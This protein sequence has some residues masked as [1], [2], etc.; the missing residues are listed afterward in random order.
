MKLWD[1]E[2]TPSQILTRKAFENAIRV[3]MAIGGSSNTVLH[4][5]ALAHEAKVD[6]DLDLFDENPDLN[7]LWHLQ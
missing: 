7:D 3:D 4:L 1:K 6:I 5:M 2:I